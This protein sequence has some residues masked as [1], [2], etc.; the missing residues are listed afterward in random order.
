MIY[1]NTV[2]WFGP[3][4]LERVLWS[5]SLPNVESYITTEQVKLIRE[6]TEK[7]DIWQ[8]IVCLHYPPV[9]P[10][11]DGC[12]YPRDDVAFAYTSHVYPRSQPPHFSLASAEV[13]HRHAQ[14]KFSS[15]IV[16]FVSGQERDAK[17]S[18]AS[19]QL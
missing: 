14:Q 7:H 16:N 11:R 12:L 15:R 8:N 18:Q 5:R 3:R 17:S 2:L 6:I 9:L 19:E 4:Q 1:G 10:Y 13:E